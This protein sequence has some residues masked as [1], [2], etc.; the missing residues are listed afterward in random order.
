MGTI[1]EAPPP[2]SSI[3]RRA[4]PTRLRRTDMPCRRATACSWRIYAR[5]WR[6][7]GRPNSPAQHGCSQHTVTANSSLSTPKHPVRSG[8]NPSRQCRTRSCSS[9]GSRCESLWAP[10]GTWRRRGRCRRFDVGSGSTARMAG[11][12]LVEWTTARRAQ[13]PG[14]RTAQVLVDSLRSLWFLCS[15]GSVGEGRAAFRC[16]IDADGVT[17]TDPELP[18]PDS[19][20]LGIDWR[21]WGLLCQW[22]RIRCWA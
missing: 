20:G 5:P 8:L 18:L 3:A 14:S 6:S 13:P 9:R 12:T 4:R 19:D 21:L 11:R 10:C 22:R 15:T 17:D 7:P 16:R 2:G 1:F